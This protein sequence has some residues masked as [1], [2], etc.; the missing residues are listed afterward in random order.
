MNRLALMMAVFATFGCGAAAW[1]ENEP[2]VLLDGSLTPQQQA[3]LSRLQTKIVADAPAPKMLDVSND[4]SVYD[5]PPPPNASTGVNSGGVKFNIDATYLNKYVYRGVDHDRVAPNGNALNLLINAEVEFDLGKFPHPLFGVT[6]NIYDSDPVSRF[7]EIL[8]Y[9]G[10]RWTI[11]PFTIET[12]LNE[13]IYP[14]R[15][16]LNTDEVYLKITLDDSFLFHSKRPV[17]QPYV[18]SA[19]DYERSN[20]WYLETGISHDFIFEEFGL[21]I[22]PKAD[23]AYI[24]HYEQNFIYKNDIGDYGFQHADMGLDIKYSLNT[25][26]NVSRRLGEFDLHGCFFYT[27]KLQA[28]V[29]GDYVLWGGF[30]LGFSY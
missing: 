14:N 5:N 13:Y 17:L 9:A 27:E 22:T 18:L 7:Q 25:L 19:F 30:G 24:S 11:A 21:T 12:A 1:A 20:G 29:T 8:P 23:V 16:S 26:F 15:E 4:E 2:P 3:I 10:A 6:T 28:T